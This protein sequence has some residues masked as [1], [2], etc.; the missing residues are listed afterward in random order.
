MTKSSCIVESAGKEFKLNNL[1]CLDWYDGPIQGVVLYDRRYFLIRYFSN[2]NNLEHLYCLF[3][4]DESPEFLETIQPG[5]FMIKNSDIDRNRDKG[6]I[7]IA[8]KGSPEII[9]KIYISEKIPKIVTSRNLDNI[10]HEDHCSKALKKIL[11][12]LRTVEEWPV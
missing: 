10:K 11:D 1:I 2:F 3:P 4:F 6:C 5:K 8:V 12:S 9:N 7:F